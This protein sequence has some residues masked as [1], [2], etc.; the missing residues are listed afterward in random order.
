MG[1][2]ALKG[3]ETPGI[4]RAERGKTTAR[5]PP[6]KLRIELKIAERAHGK[7]QQ[8]GEKRRKRPSHR[9]A[10]PPPQS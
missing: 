8:E 4:C 10:L 5:T 3:T 6:L 9:R 2:Q 7:R 1:G